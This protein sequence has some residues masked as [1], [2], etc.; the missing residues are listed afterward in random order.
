MT[1]QQQLSRNQVLPLVLSSLDLILSRKDQPPSDAVKESTHLTGD[2]A[3]VDSLDLITLV[4]DLEQRL[5]NE[6]NISLVLADGRP[7][8]GDNSPFRTVESL[9]DHICSLIDRM[10]SS[11][12]V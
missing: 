3:V 4:V 6:H 11:T 10:H 2:V 9:T 7:I 5:E 1:D 12:T 8:T